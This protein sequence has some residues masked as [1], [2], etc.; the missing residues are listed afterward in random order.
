[1]NNSSENSLFVK[2]LGNIFITIIAAFAGILVMVVTAVSALMT[3]LTVSSNLRTL[4][5][6][7]PNL[8]DKATSDHRDSATLIALLATCIPVV[9]ASFV[10]RPD[11]ATLLVLPALVGLGSVGIRGFELTGSSSN[12]YSSA[13]KIAGNIS[14]G[15]IAALAASI[16][17]IA[18]ALNPQVFVTA[19]LT[20]VLITV[21]SR[22]RKMPKLV[23]LPLAV[24]LGALSAFVHAGLLGVAVVLVAAT[25]QIDAI[26]SAVTEFAKAGDSESRQIRAKADYTVNFTL[27][28]TTIAAAALVGLSLLL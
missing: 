28:K 12:Q 18:P 20:G 21:V 3:P 26:G 27:L 8:V 6:A 10:S 5:K 2:I 24:S 4:A 16:M 23:S 7:D 1:M 25:L 17:A 22:L 14:A 15:A 11:V 9:A 13:H 19:V